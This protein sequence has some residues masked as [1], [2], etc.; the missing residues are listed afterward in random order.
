MDKIL[1]MSCL[2]LEGS[3]IHIGADIQHAS[4]ELIF[5]DM[6]SSLP[7]VSRF[8]SA[9]FRSRFGSGF[10]AFVGFCRLH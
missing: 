10:L 5:L 6:S 1:L 3:S 2:G 7:V 8:Y 4:G 9:Y